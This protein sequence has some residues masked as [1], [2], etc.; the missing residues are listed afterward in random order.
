M[1][2][3]FLRSA[4]INAEQASGAGSDKRRMS[5]TMPDGKRK[6]KGKKSE[7]TSKHGKE[8]GRKRKNRLGDSDGTGGNHGRAGN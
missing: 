3:L 6:A 2:G 4:V 8:D 7:K 1:G 5:L